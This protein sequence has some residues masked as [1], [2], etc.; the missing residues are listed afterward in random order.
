VVPR[1]GI[2]FFV[3]LTGVL[4]G[5]GEHA[6]I[7][8]QLLS[9]RFYFS[10]TA[11]VY[12]LD[13]VAKLFGRPK[14]E[15]VGQGIG[16]RKVKITMPDGEILRGEYRVTENSAA[17]FAGAHVGAVP[18]YVSGRATV[19]HATGESGVVMTCEGATE[20]GGHGSAICDTGAR[21]KFRIS[22]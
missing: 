8:D 11:N 14:V 18:G 5:C 10:D 15:F 13:D 4:T 21:G 17:G 7:S 16:N 20:P 22:Y 2:A 9:D 3:I 6:V 19:I 1:L 12:A